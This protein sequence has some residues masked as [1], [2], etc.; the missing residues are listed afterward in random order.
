M[1]RSKD[2]KGAYRS[3]LEELVAVILKRKGIPFKYEEGKIKYRSRVRGGRCGECGCKDVYR[4]RTYLPDFTLADGTVIEAK[5]RMSSPERTKF[6]DIAES[7]PDLNIV[8]IFGADNKLARGKDKRYSDWCREHGYDY[9]VKKLPDCI[10]S[11]ADG[12]ETP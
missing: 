9:A 12:F 6:L 11:L 3:K 5:G 1:R 7:N 8:F 10:A 2:V 4:E